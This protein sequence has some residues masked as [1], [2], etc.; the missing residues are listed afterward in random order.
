[1]GVATPI[2][3]GAVELP[4]FGPVANGLDASRR[5]REAL[6]RSRTTRRTRTAAL[7]LG[8]AVVLSVAAPKLA[9]GRAGTP[10]AEDPP[11]LTLHLRTGSNPA[12]AEAPPPPHV[13]GTAGAQAP[14]RARAGAREQQVAIDWHRATAHGLP[15][16]GSLSDGTQ[17]PIEGPDWVTWN[18]VEDQRPNR[19]G[20]LFGTERTIRR[21]VEVITA[22]RTAHPDAPRVLVGDIS[23]RHGGPIDEHR[24][25]QNGLDVDVYYPRRD[26]ALR[27]PVSTDQVDRRARAGPARPVRRERRG[28]G[29]RRVRGGAVRAPR[30]RGAVP[31]PREP[32][33]RPLPRLGRRPDPVPPTSVSSRGRELVVVETS[34]EPRW[35]Q[36]SNT[37]RARRA[38]RE[39]R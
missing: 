38:G 11:S 10:L 31:E 18:P 30:R 5:R 34:R 12:A 14:L 33:A 37:H 23:L 2:A 7:V 28:D 17:L 35:R 3:A 4:V 16:A 1:M 29:V 32:H 26:A 24:S 36:A 15:Y 21:I 25:H 9:G 6:R 22:Y 20:R 8:P 39:H 19:P 13:R 27:A